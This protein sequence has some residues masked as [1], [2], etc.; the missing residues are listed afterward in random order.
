M[1][2]VAAAIVLGISSLCLLYLAGFCA[3]WAWH[4]LH[5]LDAV[6]NKREE[7]G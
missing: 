1:I 5:E 6:H 4:K 2:L 7:K 3:S